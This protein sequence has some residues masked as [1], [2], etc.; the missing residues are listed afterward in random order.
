VDAERFEFVPLSETQSRLA[1]RVV[2]QKAMGSFST[3]GDPLPQDNVIRSIARAKYRSLL[4]SVTLP[5]DWEVRFGALRGRLLGW[6]AAYDAVVPFESASEVGGLGE[7]GGEGGGG[8][9]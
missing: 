9:E 4:D 6:P 5:T 1:Q 3:P 8:G 2:E 7:G